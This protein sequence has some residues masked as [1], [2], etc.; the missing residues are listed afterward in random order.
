ML[1]LDVF[2]FVEFVLSFDIAVVLDAFLHCHVHIFSFIYSCDTY[3]KD[4][5]IK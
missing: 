1:A 2:N 5:N 3:I 4:I